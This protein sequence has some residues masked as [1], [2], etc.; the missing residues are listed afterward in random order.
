[1]TSVAFGVMD[2]ATHRSSIPTAGPSVRRD[3]APTTRTLTESV[4]RM[5]G[6]LRTF[7]MS[8]LE[9]RASARAVEVAFAARLGHRRAE[10]PATRF[11]TATS[12]R[13]SIRSI[14]RSSGKIGCIK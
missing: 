1:M 12:G 11:N 6:Q 5:P 3:P 9:H 10:R 2:L 4:W 13:A 14:T 7:V 8:V